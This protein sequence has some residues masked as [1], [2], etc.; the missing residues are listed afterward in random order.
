M[1]WELV[2][3]GFRF[4]LCTQ[5]HNPN[6]I[7]PNRARPCDIC[8]FTFNLAQ[9]K[10]IE[11]LSPLE[12]YILQNLHYNTHSCTMLQGYCLQRVDGKI[13]ILCVIR[14]P[15][16]Q[17]YQIHQG[18][19]LHGEY[20]RQSLAQLLAEYKQPLWQQ[21]PRAVYT[22]SSKHETWTITRG[23]VVLY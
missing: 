4:S 19:T 3:G 11:N 2:S 9:R 21:S 13:K 18:W 15:T 5:N 12:M 17:H 8:V 1:C 16:V 10:S 20:G 14:T 23:R 6:Q 22:D 7:L